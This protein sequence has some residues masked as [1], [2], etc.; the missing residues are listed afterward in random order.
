MKKS[1]LPW[2]KLDKLKRPHRLGIFFGTIAVLG[3]VFFFLLYQPLQAEITELNEDIEKLE[4]QILQHTIKA[5]KI[6][7]IKEQLKLVKLRFEFASRLLPDR[8]EVDQLLRDISDNG[9]QAGLNVILFQPQIKD[10]IKD[11][12][13]EISFDMKVEG[14]YLN[15]ASFFYRVG[16]L[17][18]IVNIADINISNPRVVEGDMILSASCK[19]VT[20]RFL[21]PAELAAREEA[22]AAK[23]KAKA[24]AKAKAKAKAK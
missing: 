8:K 4:N 10:T 3:A 16:R 6:P 5:K 20:F 15:I 18:R 13:A 19:G 7:K 14:P 2:E 12:Y 1:I 9:A 23:A 17:P 21:T 11:F 24:R 22:A